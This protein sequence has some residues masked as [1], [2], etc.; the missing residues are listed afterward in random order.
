MLRLSIFALCLLLT[1]C[2]HAR[3]FLHMD[4]NSPSPFFGL[5]LS[6]DARD[7]KPNDVPV[8]SV[9]TRGPRQ[10]S[11][12]SDR[13]NGSNGKVS[14]AV[15]STTVRD[16]GFVATSEVSRQTSTVKYSLPQIDLSSNP[17]DAAEIEDIV[18][19]IAN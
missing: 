4:S 15:K 14:V 5:Q 18:S 19:R 2:E 1:G 12:K 9:G 13:V 11:V 7:V 3:S 17:D 10:F 6:V 16:T 8:V